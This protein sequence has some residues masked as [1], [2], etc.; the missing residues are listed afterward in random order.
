MPR[1]D[2]SPVLR[3]KA[4]TELQYDT[5]AISPQGVL[6]RD[7][8][9][10]QRNRDPRFH[11][12]TPAEIEKTTPEGF[13]KVWEPALEEGPIEVQVYG[14][15][16]R[17]ATI[18]TLRRTFGALAPRKPLPRAIAAASV[19]FPPPTAQ[20]V[21]ITHR[22]DANQ[23]AAVVSW[24]T[25][26]GSIGISQSRELEILTQLFTNRLMDAMR[27]KTG[28]SYA[29][30]VYSTWPLDLDTGGSITAM[31]QLRPEA[32]PVFFQTAREIATDLI[33][34][35]ASA[36]ELA[37]VT[38]PLRQQVTR[39]ATSSAF[40]MYQLEGATGDPARFASIQTLLA[41]YTQTTPERMQ[42]LAR[43][44]LDPAKSWRLAVMPEAKPEP[45]VSATR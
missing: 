20:P 13:R 41:D 18:A 30:Q 16:D 36:D 35:P 24:P 42:A 23:A 4:A 12:P 11:T 2:A 33:A 38:E 15:F 3:A 5:Y 17:A 31:A 22:G 27:E 26:G 19:Q 9:F 34:R 37:R 44:Y 32:V 40:F 43:Q 10:L 7:L 45:V 39:A 14:D 8:K 29:P 1:W 21:V 28:A 6:N 25:G